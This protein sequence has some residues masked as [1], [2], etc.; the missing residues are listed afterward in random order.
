[1]RA[2]IQTPV[3]PP[4]PT[5]PHLP[6]NPPIPDPKLG[7]GD[8]PEDQE[9]DLKLIVIWLVIVLYMFYG[10]AHVCEDFLVPGLNILCERRKIPEDVA[11]ATLMA[12]GCNAPELFASGIGVFIQHSTVGAGTVVG[13]T[14]FNILCICGAASFAV[15]GKLF[16]DGWLMFREIISL[17]VVLCIFLWVMN[18]SVVLWW[19]ALI[20]CSSY[21]GYVLLCVYYERM[22]KCCLRRGE[23]AMPRSD[24]A[25]STSSLSSPAQVVPLTLADVVPS[26]VEHG[27]LQGDASSHPFSSSNS[28]SRVAKSL[29][30][31]L[32]Q[33]GHQ[34]IDVALPTAGEPTLVSA[35]VG[36]GGEIYGSFRSAVATPAS[37][38]AETLLSPPPTDPST[39]AA[40]VAACSHRCDD[41]LRRGALEAPVGDDGERIPVRMAGV[42]FKKSRFYSRVRMGKRI[43][44]RRFFVLH[45]N[46]AE[47]SPLCYHRIGEDGTVLWDQS[48][49]VPLHEVQSIVR[50]SSVEIHM[51]S[52]KTIYKLRCGISPL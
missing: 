42:L 49:A 23:T 20:L 4:G 8:H 7:C 36:R 44:Q 34:A 18:D 45:K 40:L 15:G 5:P 28:L 46:I 16:V 33:T 22:L 11:G 43:W 35:T 17:I 38:Y 2:V 6:P 37:G 14:P 26:T 31:H 27:S 41:Y 29:S 12:A 13:S 25:M 3:Q 19:E 30:M 50:F 10:L 39:F 51:V 52:A 48:V 1:M 32:M 21:V 47:G 24:G 9:G